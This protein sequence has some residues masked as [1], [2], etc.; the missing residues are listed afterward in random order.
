MTF[1][2]WDSTTIW[3]NSRAC[4]SNLVLTPTAFISMTINTRMTTISSILNNPIFIVKSTTTFLLIFEK[5]MVTHKICI[6]LHLFQVLLRKAAVNPLPGNKDV[7]RDGILTHFPLLPGPSRFQTK[8]KTDTAT[9]S[10]QSVNK[11][12]CWEFAHRISDRSF[13]AKKVSE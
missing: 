4:A 3:H 12:Q 7:F 5:L 11:M 9:N 2:N 6:P 8:I 10:P 13:F 1:F